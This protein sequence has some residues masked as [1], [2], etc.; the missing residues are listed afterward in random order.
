MR[1]SL[2]RKVTGDGVR[3]EKQKGLNVTFFLK[4]NYNS[5]RK[6]LSNIIPYKDQSGYNTYLIKSNFPQE[7]YIIIREM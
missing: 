3:K 7:K 6:S 5:Q 1:L 2:F 4:L